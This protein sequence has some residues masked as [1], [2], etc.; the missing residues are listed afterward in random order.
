MTLIAPAKEI[1]DA[2]GP[3]T[4]NESMIEEGFK[5]F[6]KDDTNPKDKA[7]PG[8]PS[9]LEDKVL[10]EIVEQ[11][12]NASTRILLA[13]YY[14]SESIINRYHNKITLWTS[15]VYLKY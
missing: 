9:V 5:G 15:V 13:E 12:P 7:R 14:P 1:N 2:D 6:Q 8:I 11:L 4:V 10:L 3:G